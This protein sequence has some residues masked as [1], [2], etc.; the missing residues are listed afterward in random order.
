MSDEDAP[1]VDYEGEEEDE[2]Q[3]IPGPAVADGGELL[4]AV[5]PGAGDSETDDGSGSGDDDDDEAGGGPRPPPPSSG[6]TK[7]GVEDGEINGGKEGNTDNKK[8]TATTTSGS[9]GLFRPH[10][11]SSIMDRALSAPRET[12]GKQH[13]RDGGN[14]NNH[15]D[16]TN[17]NGFGGGGGRASRWGARPNNGSEQRT[18]MKQP[19]EEKVSVYIPPAKRRL[20]EEQRKA[21]ELTAKESID[22]SGDGVEGGDNKSTSKE[23]TSPTKISKAV[24]PIHIQRQTWES[25]QRSING[26]INRLSPSTIKPLI[27]SLFSDAN[28]LRGRGVL[29]RSILHAAQASPQYAPTY[30]ALMAVVNTK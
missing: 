13:P 4:A 15:R 3:G 28:L 10:A 17:Q 24:T 6:D 1:D 22:S 20:L 11:P 25:L 30:T 9:D 26:T 23:N 7:G 5:K 27:H 2:E 14:G 19:P 16:T 8:D 21:A 18:M 29:T 12:P